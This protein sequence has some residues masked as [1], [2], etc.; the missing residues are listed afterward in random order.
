MKPRPECAPCFLRQMAIASRLA[1]ADR[2]QAAKVQTATSKLIDKLGNIH[3]PPYIATVLF[4]N[5]YR[6]LGVKDPYL[7][8][9]EEYNRK[10][11]SLYPYLDKLIE[12]SS[13]SLSESIK[14]ALAG[15]II[16]F[17]ILEKFNLNRTLSQTLRI[18]LKASKIAEIRSRIKKAGLILYIADNAGEIGFDRFLLTD[19]RRINPEAKVFFSVKRTPIINDATADD[20]R[21]FR[22]EELARIINSGDSW[23]GTHPRLCSPAFR[24]IFAKAGLIIS[25]GQANYESLE[26]LN[27]PRI[28][29]LLK[30]KCPVVSR[31]LGVKLNEVVIK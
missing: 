12:K 5:T 2:R 26:E 14:M 8:L 27:D 11:L 24:K 25:K 18:K 3:N 17:G 21:F 10:V 13:N 7:L 22:L 30:A 16:D 9:K 28:L 1:A 29:F 31:N 19:I 15:N 4:R 23:I 6:I 20:A